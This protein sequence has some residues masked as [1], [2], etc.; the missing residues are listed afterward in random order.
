MKKII[1]NLEKSLLQPEVRSSVER[2]DQLLAHDFIEFGSDGRIYNK[3]Q[4]LRNLPKSSE[5]KFS[6][7]NFNAKELSKNV[8]LVTY[9]VTKKTNRQKITRSL[10]CSI[11]KKSGSRWQMVFHQGTAK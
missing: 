4:I 11:W 9:Q 7:N 6:I 1:Y 3:K 5:V 2:L 8:V 10:R